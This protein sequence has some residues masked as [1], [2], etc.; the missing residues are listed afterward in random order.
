MSELQLWEIL[1][2][3]I[4]SNGKP[5][6]TRFHRVWDKKVR[7]IS[8]G[9]TVLQ[10]AKGT[11]VHPYGDVFQ[12]R[13]IPVRVACAKDQIAKIAEMT[14]KYYEQHTIMYYRVSDK[15]V[16]YKGAENVD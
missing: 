13:M 1:V 15:V 7:D 12:E 9:L 8:G 14:L 6:H 5:Y 3:T 16:F 4:R 11:W 10:P 2:P